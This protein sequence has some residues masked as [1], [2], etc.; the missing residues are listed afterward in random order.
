MRIAN[1]NSVGYSVSISHFTNIEVQNENNGLFTLQIYSIF[2]HLVLLYCVKKFGSAKETWWFNH[3]PF[4]FGVFSQWQTLGG[5]KG[6]ASPPI[7]FTE[8]L[9]LSTGKFSFQEKVK[10]LLVI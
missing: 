2:Q 4:A 9:A 10:S 1:Q 7:I 8:A 6:G 5:A 3:F